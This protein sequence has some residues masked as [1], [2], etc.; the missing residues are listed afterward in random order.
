MLRSKGRKKSFMNRSLGRMFFIIHVIRC[1]VFISNI[2][3]LGMISQASLGFESIE[4]S[5]EVAISPF[6]NSFAFSYLHQN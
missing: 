2:R 6:L 3:L 4:C 1:R 5:L